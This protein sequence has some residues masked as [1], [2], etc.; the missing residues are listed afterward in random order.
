MPV[1]RDMA[2]EWA[3]GA[4]NKLLEPKRRDD[5]ETNGMN[6]IRYA[7]Y[8]LYIKFIN[9]EQFIAN[10]VKSVT[11]RDDAKTSELLREIALAEKSMHASEIPT[12]ATDIAEERLIKKRKSNKDARI[13]QAADRALAADVAETRAD[14]L[15]ER[16][17]NPKKNRRR[18]LLLQEN[19][20]VAVVD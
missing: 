11:E 4:V 8:R 12:V 6:T 5:V 10:A 18:Q 3:S 1:L 16:L 20:S 15:A 2:P 13:Q 7:Q 19:E 14:D 9:D 17:L